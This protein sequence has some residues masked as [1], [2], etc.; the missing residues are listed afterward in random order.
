MSRLL[1]AEHFFNQPR[2]LIVWQ[3]LGLLGLVS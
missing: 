2:V 1:S 3:P